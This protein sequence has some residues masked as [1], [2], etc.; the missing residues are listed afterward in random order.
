MAQRQACRPSDSDP[1]G[2]RFARLRFLCALSGTRWR[3]GCSHCAG[4][5]ME[6]H[7]LVFLPTKRPPV[8]AVF[9][10]VMIRCEL[11]GEDQHGDHRAAGRAPIR[12]T[13]SRMKGSRMPRGLSVGAPFA[14]QQ[15]EQ[16]SC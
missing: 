7:A 12:Q 15:R 16:Y 6:E 14:R 4:S 3:L 5:Y 1:R 13:V 11:A 10:V 8:A 9:S 2:S